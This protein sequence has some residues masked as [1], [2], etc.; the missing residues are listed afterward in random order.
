MRKN[1]EFWGW[2]V[3]WIVVA[4]ILAFLI[5]EVLVI[6]EKIEEHQYE[7]ERQLR[8]TSLV[9]SHGRINYA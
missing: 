9:V 6:V 3:F 7:W 2:V 4:L 8:E 1:S 5:I